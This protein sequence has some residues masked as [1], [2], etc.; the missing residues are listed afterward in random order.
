MTSVNAHAGKIRR[1]SGRTASLSAIPLVPLLLATLLCAPGCAHRAPE[2]TQD[3]VDTSLREAADRIAADLAALSGSHQQLDIPSG[4]GVLAAP[5]DIDFDGPITQALERICA[6]TGFR[7]AMVGHPRD[8]PVIVHLH[9]R[10]RTVLDVLRD[11]GLQTGP[12]ERLRVVEQTRL[13]EL[14]W[15]DPAP[16]VPAPAKQRT[17]RQS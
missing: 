5:M 15:L 2:K 10:G 17:R 12:H 13:I 7:L 14:V 6:R 8:V 1:R 3:V 9:S 11:I 16:A 4:A